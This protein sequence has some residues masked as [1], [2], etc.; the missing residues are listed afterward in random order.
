M[1]YYE[2]EDLADH[3]SAMIRFAANLARGKPLE[4]HRGSARAWMHVSDAVR[5]VEAAAHVEH[6]AAINIGHPHVVPMSELAE[7]IRAELNA[8]PALIKTVLLPPKMT[9]VKR[10]V[11]ERQRL[12]LGF[13]PRVSLAEGVRRVCEVQA[14]LA[15]GA[16]STSLEVARVTEMAPPVLASTL[17]RLPS[18]DNTPMA[19]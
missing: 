3:R 19:M 16:Y 17:E 8:D 2:H 9:L 1:I 4:A 18:L 5:A 6:Y 11:L 7:M 12:L 15:S 10:P 13:E 14:R